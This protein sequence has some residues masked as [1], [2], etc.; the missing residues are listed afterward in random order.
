LVKQGG[1]IF[2]KGAIHKLR[3]NILITK[4]EL[5]TLDRMLFE[6]GTIGTKAEFIKSL[7]RT[8]FVEIYQKYCWPRCLGSKTDLWRDIKLPNLKRTTNMFYGCDY[9]FP[10]CKRNN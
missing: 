5:E 9:Q 10:E 7:R 6:Q 3:N 1:K 4:G 2:N 8:T